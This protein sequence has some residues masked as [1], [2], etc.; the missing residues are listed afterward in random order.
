MPHSFGNRARTRDTYSKK[1]RGMGSATQQLTVYKQGQYVDIRVDPC[2]LK[3]M[4]YRYY[5]GRTGKIFHVVNR[6]VG[7]LINKRVR[8]R[9]M[10]KRIYVRTEHIRPSKCRTAF[11]ERVKRNQMLAEEAKKTGT[12]VQLKRQPKGPQ[13]GYLVE[14]E[15]GQKVKGLKIRPAVE[16]VH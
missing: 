2:Y 11:V 6:A 1:K 4:P 5:H 14:L 10:V 9:I 12:F 16:V 13:A 7:V 15:P 8:H 3:G